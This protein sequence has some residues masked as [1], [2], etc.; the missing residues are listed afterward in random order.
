MLNGAAVLMA[1]LFVLRL[2]QRRVAAI[3]AAILTGVVS[4][5]PAYYVSWGRYTQLTGL[6]LLPAALVVTLDWLEVGRRD[7]RLLLAAGALWGGLAVTHARV[8]VFGVCFVAAILLLESWNRY[9]AAG[10]TAWELWRRL[11]FLGFA[12]LAVAG[13]WIQ[14]VAAGI[15]KAIQETGQGP[16]ADAT[17][18]ALSAALLLAPRN[19][20]LMI[21]ATVGALWGVCR[22]RRESAWLILWMVLVA[23]VTNPGWLGLPGSNFLNNSTAAIALY[24]PLTA[25]GGQAVVALWEIGRLL[26]ARCGST[27][28]RVWRGTAAT[29]LGIVALA[30][31]WGMVSIVNPTTVLVTPADMQAMAWIRENTPADALFLIN[32]RPWQLGIYVGV[33]GGY[34]I[35]RLTGRQTLLPEL[36]YVYGRPDDVRRI[37]EAARTVSET[38]SGAESELMDVIREWAATHIYTGAKGGALTPQ[39]FLDAGPY[40]PVYSSGEVWIFEV[41]G[42][43]P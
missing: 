24:V 39:M 3:A 30:G 40:R 13:P 22:R 36:P 33:D 29:I 34:W 41:E 23:L 18:N 31:A 4:Y 37:T 28:G 15:L 32:V 12:S 8:I 26:S 2:S 21:L 7:W 20:E 38:T 5:M 42:S 27:W 1:Y 19:R 14:R 16:T 43:R 11:A 35:R 10:P 25:L 9:R 17:Y 6:L